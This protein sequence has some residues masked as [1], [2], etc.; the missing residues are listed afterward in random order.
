M[1]LKNSELPLRG[2]GREM[3]AKT[4]KRVKDIMIPVEDYATVFLENTIRDAMFVL[5]NTFY[6]VYAVGSQAHRS[7]L[8]FDNRKKLV[9]TLSFRDII[10]SLQTHEDE[11]NYLE[12]MFQNL[13][14]LQAGRKVKEVM[15]P[16][17]EVKVHANDS[18]L[19]AIN[20]L[21]REDLE[22]VPVEE[23][24]GIIGMVRSVEIFKE[25]SEFV[26]ANIFN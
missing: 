2:V 15:R 5:K 18:I 11:P 12:G 16:V 7:V 19:N 6:S 26:E 24:G 14:L 3:L 22:L 21:M 8:V 1:N 13:C 4:E 10:A 25:V 23:N 20:L 17:G 9:G